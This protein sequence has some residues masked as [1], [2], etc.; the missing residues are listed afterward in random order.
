MGR[1]WQGA[2]TVQAVLDGEL[3]EQAA[4]SGLRSLFLGFE[5][6]NAGSLAGC[7][8]RHNLV[9][10]Y[11]AA[12]KRLHDLGVMVNASFVFGMD[13]DDEDVFSRTV[14]WAVR[15]SIE[16]ATFHILTPYPG[17]RLHQR[18]QQQGRLL[19]SNWDLFDTRHAVFQPARMSTAALERGYWQA[20]RDFYS[21]CS[22]FAAAAA[23]ATPAQRLRH[24]AYTGG[25]KKCEALWSLIVSAKITGKMR[26]LLELVL[27]SRSSG[28]FVQCR[29]V[30]EHNSEQTVLAGT[31][32]LSHSMGPE[33]V[34]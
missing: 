18:L 26:P 20:Y 19:S 5:T 12:V 34:V 15:N 22:I 24:L 1:L 3:I 13:G 33:A 31:Q 8:K 25:W 2:G 21:W 9:A 4:K 11:E 17:T 28:R 23:K 10:Q 29:N 30:D 6:L 16:T 32:L 7:N 14:D 27:Q